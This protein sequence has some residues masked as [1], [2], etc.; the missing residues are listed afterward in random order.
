MLYENTMTV[1]S[2]TRLEAQK[3]VYHSEEYNKLDENEQWIRLSDGCPNNCPYCYAPTEK[4]WYGLPKIERKK[5]SI[6]DMNLLCF[7]EKAEETLKTLIDSKAQI[8]LT[9]GFDYRFLTP[10]RAKLLRTAKI[11]YFDKKGNWHRR[12]RFAWDWGLDKTYKILDA[13]NMLLKAGFKPDQIMVFMLCNWQIS[14]EVCEKKLDILKVWGCLVSDC[15]FDNQTRGKVQPI[16]WTPSQIKQF[17]EK[18]RDHNILIN[19]RGVQP[20][21]IQ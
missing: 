12:I 16:H 1:E 13:K 6:L 8:D 2:Q 19:L 7:E 18:C 14:M 5:V 10:E 3:V 21:W 11:G 4:K 15:W 17:S 9:C 20:E